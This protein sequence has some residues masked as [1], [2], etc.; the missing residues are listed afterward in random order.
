MQ[1]WSKLADGAENSYPTLWAE[2]ENSFH[3]MDG[4]RDALHRRKKSAALSAALAAFAADDSQELQ[5]LLA[6]VRRFACKIVELM[7]D[8][9]SRKYSEIMALD[10]DGPFVVEYI[11]MARMWMRNAYDEC[12]TEDV[13]RHS[14]NASVCL[15]RALTDV[16]QAYLMR[17]LAI[18]KMPYIPDL[19]YTAAFNLEVESVIPVEKR[20]CDM[21][22][23]RA[24]RQ[25]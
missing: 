17:S 2:L 21:M 25:M 23:I 1:W 24:R 16:K 12:Y 5:A 11:S 20:L 10:G 8:V 19:E 9:D 7:G 18:Y 15:Y 22:G 3:S 13:K 14:L 6:I 4:I